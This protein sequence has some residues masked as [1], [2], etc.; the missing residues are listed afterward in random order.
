[1]EHGISLTTRPLVVCDIDE[2]VLEFL[3]PFDLFL[4][5]R[6]LKLL[7]RSFRLHGNIVSIE[8]GMEAERADVDILQEEFFADQ[9]SWQVPVRNVIPSL[10]ML[11]ETADVIFLTAMPPRHHDIRRGLLDSHSLTFPMISTEEPKGKVLK[12]LHRDRDVPVVFIDDIAYNLNSVYDHLPGVGLIHLMA[13]DDF[14][15]L[16]PEP[17]DHVSKANDWDHAVQLVQAHFSR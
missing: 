14:R 2:V 9:K 6:G 5:S 4:R 11:S 7:P 3:T 1:M 10:H 12:D 17:G 13:N 8:T 16:A 15:A